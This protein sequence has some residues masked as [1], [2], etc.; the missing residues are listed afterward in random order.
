MHVWEMIFEVDKGM[1]LAHNPG[2]W[3]NLA[4]T[5]FTVIIMIV[6]VKKTLI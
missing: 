3:R 1:M 4:L 6:K 5:V 2:Q